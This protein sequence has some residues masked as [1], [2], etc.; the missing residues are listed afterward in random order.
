M[1]KAFKIDLERLQKM[2]SYKFHYR[3]T[4]DAILVKSFR[5]GHLEIKEPIKLLKTALLRSNSG[6]P[7]FV[8]LAK[9]SIDLL[10]HAR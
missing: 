7:I 8:T 5:V 3:T 2:K 4:K 9:D 10:R 1:Q 6:I